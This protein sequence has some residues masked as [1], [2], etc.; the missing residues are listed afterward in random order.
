[1]LNFRGFG[2]Q[3]FRAFVGRAPVQL[4]ASAREGVRAIQSLM[5]GKT[6][7]LLAVALGLSASD[8]TSRAGALLRSLDDE[9][10]DEQTSPEEVEEAWADELKRRAEDLRSGRV[11]AV[12]WDQVRKQLEDSISRRGG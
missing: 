9:E 12:P 5:P 6:E 4:P 3:L 1:M 10:F 7:D 2:P 11:A 8:R